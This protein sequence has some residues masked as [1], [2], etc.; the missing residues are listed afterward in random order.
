MTHSPHI[1]LHMLLYLHILF[2][3][4][5]VTKETNVYPAHKDTFHFLANFIWV[6]SFLKPIASILNVSVWFIA[7]WV[8]SEHACLHIFPHRSQSS[9]CIYRSVYIKPRKGKLQPA[10]RK[11]IVICFLFNTSPVVYRVPFPFG[12][13]L[14]INTSA[15][16]TYSDIS[17]SLPL[18]IEQLLCVIQKRAR[19]RKSKSR[20]WGGA[21]RTT[22]TPCRSCMRWWVIFGPETVA[23]GKEM[24]FLRSDVRCL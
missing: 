7:T 20:M 23:V 8:S 9:A 14:Q 13:P 11:E 19:K 18:S 2:Y 3:K 21:Q 16:F 5:W 15:W 4:L 1:C 17:R 12:Q 24:C 22:S 10:W 6:W